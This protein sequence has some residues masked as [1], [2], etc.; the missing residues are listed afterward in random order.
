MVQIQ[1]H[2]PDLPFAQDWQVGT[3]GSG[4]GIASSW[5]DNTEWTVNPPGSGLAALSETGALFEVA[6]PPTPGGPLFW[7]VG[8]LDPTL[9]AV[10]W[11]FGDVN[12]GTQEIAGYRP[13]V[14]AAWRGPGEGAVAVGVFMAGATP[15]PLA[16]FTALWVDTDAGPVTGAISQWAAPITYDLGPSQNPAIALTLDTS[17]KFIRTRRRIS[18]SGW[19]ISTRPRAQSSAGVLVGVS[20]GRTGRAPGGRCLRHDR[21]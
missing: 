19:V 4:L 9:S 8:Q 14:G 12:F 18:H 11:P 2:Y 15:G 13:R 17:S 16:S 6:S 1:Q 3:I 7:F 5:T 21:H 20:G 10:D